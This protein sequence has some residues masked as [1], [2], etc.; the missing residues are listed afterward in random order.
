M[1]PFLVSVSSVRSIRNVAF[2]SILSLLV[3]QGCSGNTQGFSL[4]LAN[5]ISCQAWK[6]NT[7]YTKGQTVQYN[8][9]LQYNLNNSGGW[10]ITASCQ[11]SA[12]L[13]KDIQY[14]NFRPDH[15]NV[16][17]LPLEFAENSPKPYSKKS[18]AKF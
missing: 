3:L 13:G 14:E 10:T 9:Y 2:S 5:G 15:S 16:K 17:N 8:G 1:T 6:P 18:F 12:G 4:P 7:I 11:T